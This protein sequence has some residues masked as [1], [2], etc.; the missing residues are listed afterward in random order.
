MASENVKKFNKALMFAGIFNI[1]GLLL[2]SFSLFKVTPIT[3]ILSTGV[4]GLL[5]GMAVL[6]YLKVV[7]QDLRKQKIL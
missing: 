2:V 4:G 6:L 7:I 1:I 3:I 5:I